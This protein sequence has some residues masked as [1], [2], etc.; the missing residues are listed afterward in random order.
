MSNQSLSDIQEIP[1]AKVV[2]AFKLLAKYLLKK[3]WVLLIV[4]FIGG[5]LGVLVATIQKAKY[6]SSLSFSLEDGGNSLGG[7]LGLAA[8]FGFNFGGGS[9]N[10]FSGENIISIVTSRRI[11]EQTLLAVDTL[12]GKP[13]TM[14]EY[15]ISINKWRKKAKSNSVLG[16]VSF[17]VGFSRGQ[18]SYLQDSVLFNIQKEVSKNLVAS[19][20]DKKLNIYDIS[21]VSPDEKFT[22][23]FTDKLID[24]TIRFYTSLRLKKSKQILDILEERMRSMEGAVKGAISQKA[25]LQDANINP[26]FAEQSAQLQKKQVDVTAY[27]AA[28]EEL[29]KSLEMARYQYLSDAPLLQVIDGADYPMK[30]IKNGRLITGIIWALAATLLAI[31]AFCIRYV[32]FL[33]KKSNQKEL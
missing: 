6:Q 32:R 3:W 9:G 2:T 11:I 1:F 20:R 24:E 15:F 13:I 27:G 30:R 29:F 12:E 17:P 18:L 22:K 23:K 21:F 16:R 10:V 8:E 28:Y 31:L 19:R 33:S 7:A 5:S 25:S 26:A 14:A 4:G